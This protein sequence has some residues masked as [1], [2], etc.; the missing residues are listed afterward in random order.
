M[1]KSQY[2]ARAG[3]VKARPCLAQGNRVKKSVT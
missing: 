2:L 1:L 3:I